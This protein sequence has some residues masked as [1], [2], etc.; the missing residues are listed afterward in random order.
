MATPR[1]LITGIAGQDGSYLAELL[2]EKGYSVHGMVRT[3]STDGLERI[4]HIRDRVTLHGGD[5]LDGASLSEVVR[6]ARP[7]EVYNLA[8]MSFVGVS[9]RQPILTAETT[10]LGATRLLA[11][12]REAGPDAR[13]YQASSSE[14]F[15]AARQSPQNEETPFHPRSPYGVAKAYAHYSTVNY[16]ES[17]GMFA[18]SG[19]LFNHESPRRGLQFVSRKITRTAAAIKLGLANELLLGNLD[20]ARDWGHARDYVHAMWLMLQQPSP[21]DY[22][23]G[24]GRSFSVR[25]LLTLAFAQ[26]DLDWEAYVKVDPSLT[27]PAEVERL[28]ADCSKARR[29]MDWEPATSF[30]QLI[31]EMVDADLASLAQGDPATATMP[32]G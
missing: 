25:D 3:G 1:A 27:R 8:G 26:V 11:A 31:P 6:H 5:L 7:D 32:N 28:V 20:A 19:I 24:T 22:V 13:Y 2:L 9:W 4:S 29:V 15:G 10:G 16:R 21:D 18:C 12:V 17:Y 23:I 14:M 30:E